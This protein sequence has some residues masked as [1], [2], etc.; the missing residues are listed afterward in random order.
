MS[1]ILWM[2]FW[3]CFRNCEHFILNLKCT[4]IFWNFASY[5]R[6][7]VWRW[8]YHFQ[9]I[10][11]QS[12]NPNFLPRKF[13]NPY[14]T[15]FI[16]GR[17]P[18]GFRDDNELKNTSGFGPR[19][20]KP[21]FKATQHLKSPLPPTGP[22]FSEEWMKKKK[23]RYKVKRWAHISQSVLGGLFIAISFLIPLSAPSWDFSK[24]GTCQ[25]GYSAGANWCH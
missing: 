2:E 11:H 13:I 19:P 17:V 4:C 3:V 25:H 12:S 21:R 23:E 15:V 6:E 7:W 16:E 5:V 18:L 20:S 10:I 22:N 14:Y 24:P 9:I 8:T 1:I